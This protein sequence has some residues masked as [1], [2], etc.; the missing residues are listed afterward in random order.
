M[1]PQARSFEKTLAEGARTVP[2]EGFSFSLIESSVRSNSFPLDGV[3]TVLSYRFEGLPEENIFRIPFLYRL[4]HQGSDLSVAQSVLAEGNLPVW[5]VRP[6]TVTSTARLLILSAEGA[7][8]PADIVSVAEQARAEVEEALPFDLDPKFLV[9]LA[10]NEA[11]YR[12]YLPPAGPVAGPRV[13]QANTSFRS[14]P[15]D[16][17]VEARHIIVNLE[18]LA[19]DR[20]GLQTFKHELSHLALAGL[21]TPAM[22]AWVAESAAMYLAGQK[23]NWTQRVATGNFD[24]L[25]FA[26]LSRNRSLGDQDPSGETAALQYSY[27]AGAAGYLVETFGANRYWDFYRSYVEVPAEELYRSL[28]SGAG[29]GEEGLADLGAATT[30]QNLKEHFDLTTAELDV[31]VRNWLANEA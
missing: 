7:A 20:T 25:S 8:D 18:G 14:T 28:P 11:E 30:E 17:R 6:V 3:Q 13:A 2:V 1:S 12:R 29:A 5:A 19:R 22:P 4:E 31:A 21:T 9:V 10:E 26:D 24:G 23:T 16:F 27:A 15:R